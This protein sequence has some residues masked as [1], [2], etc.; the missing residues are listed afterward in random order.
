[1]VYGLGM[2]NICGC[3]TYYVNWCGEPCCE[4]CG[5]VPASMVYD[6]DDNEGFPYDPYGYDDSGFGDED[7]DY[8]DW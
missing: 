1:M 6:E 3:P 4:D 8:Y 7:D 5:G 2:C